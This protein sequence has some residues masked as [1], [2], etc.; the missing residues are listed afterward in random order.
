MPG[1]Y[2]ELYAGKL[3]SADKCFK[4]IRKH[5]KTRPVHGEC[6]G[7]MV[8][9]KSLIDKDGNAHDMLGLLGLV[10]LFVILDMNIFT[11]S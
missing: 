11:R 9:G 6:G 8:L 4:A 1:G 10:L 7:Y 2:P 3:A 5:A